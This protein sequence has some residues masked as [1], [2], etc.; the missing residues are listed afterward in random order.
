VVEK[1]NVMRML[2]WLTLMAMS[3]GMDVIR[4]AEPAMPLPV[5]REDTLVDRWLAKPVQASRM[6]CDMEDPSVWE[7]LGAG[8]ITISDE[9]AR[10]GTQSLKMT[11]K[12]F[13]DHPSE[14][15]R[16][17]GAC[18]ARFKVD[19][20]N[21]SDFNR[22]SFWVYP[23]LPG[24]RT[25]SM[26][27]VLR[28]EGMFRV[29]DEYGRR[30]RNYFVLRNR[31]WNHVVWEIAHLGRDKV[32]G[33]EFIYRMQGHEPGTADT[34]RYYIDTLE[35]QKV[36]PDH[37]EGWNVAP[38]RIA[39]SHTGYPLKGSKIAITSDTIPD[40]FAV[41]NSAGVT[42]REYP[43]RQMR[44]ALGGF[45][46]LDFSELGDPGIY[47]LRAGPLTTEPFR[48]GRDVWQ[49]TVW[50]TIN[51][52]YC[53]RCGMEIPGIHGLCHEDWLAEHDGKKLTYNGGWHDAGDL[54]QGLRNTSE[55]AYAMFL[56][57][58]Q[59][60]GRSAALADRL[61]EEARWGLDWILKN[62]FGDGYRATWGTM[63]F[64]TDNFIGTTDDMLA[65]RVS[66]DAYHNFHA[67][68]AEAIGSRLLQK[69]HPYLAARSLKY[70]REDWE[71]AIKQ[72][73]QSTLQ[74]HAIGLVASVELFV[75][76][77]EM[78]YAKKAVE[79][80]DTILACQQ[81]EK[82]AWEIPLRGFFYRS[83]AKRRIQHYSHIGEIQSPITGLM[84]LCDALPDHPKR[85]QWIDCVRLYASYLTTIADYTAPYHTFPASI[86]S[87]DESEDTRFREQ[88]KSGIRL[89]DTH[90]LR[91]FPVWFEL[92]GHYG[93]LLSQ[94]RA[95]SAAARL[96]NDSHLADLASRQ[97]QW[98]VGL[99]PFCQSTMYGEGH[100]FAP[101]YSAT[102]GNIVG[103]LPVGIQTSRN[104]DEPFWPA[105]NCYN[106]KE[107]WVH[108]SSRWLA[109][110]ADLEAL[111]SRK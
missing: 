76:T 55:A 60:E 97:L 57:A 101:Q 64:W 110:L 72:L 26:S 68:T 17:P 10:T 70:A 107:I 88:V 19:N 94:A 58:E 53:L 5:V 39:Y 11:C 18:T 38:G 45:S 99:N 20:E 84:M 59:L 30:G 54:S 7:H 103:G 71:F 67:V 82:P 65:R 3:I 100:D 51:C 25:I 73:Q 36:V 8:R 13:T 1:G 108:P 4:A 27:V 92:R 74:T 2:L 52:F 9:Y 86:Y 35:L 40:E 95:M 14:N 61:L 56:L 90:Y 79:L 75:A 106:F 49:G 48:V 77:Q 91:R 37:Y 6:L 28:N 22:L 87:L 109:I 23:Y 83:P 31:Q 41:I 43:V 50:K 89:S 21:W 69:D 42:V 80:A 46:I 104:Q 102:S 24:F 93:V 66:N 78:D 111:K 34:V 85:A 81:R 29:P 33:V 15:G 12:T 44:T 63:D 105:D 96:L 16:P 47:T 98:V 62:R 32:T